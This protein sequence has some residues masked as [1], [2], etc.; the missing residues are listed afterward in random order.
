MWRGYERV[1]SIHIDVLA[2]MVDK[3]A[4]KADVGQAPTP[5]DVTE[6][7]YPLQ[8]GRQFEERFGGADA[9][10]SLAMFALFLGRYAAF[11]DRIDR[12]RADGGAWRQERDSLL[13]RAA[14]LRKIAASVRA[15]LASENR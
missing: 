2:G 12:T 10:R 14:K 7:L 4:W 5:N 8:R 9:P 1:L 11:A 3:I 15:Q 6:L 13:R